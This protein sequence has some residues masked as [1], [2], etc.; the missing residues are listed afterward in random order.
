MKRI[1]QEDLDEILSRTE[2]YWRELARG[3]IFLTGC[4][5]FFGVWILECLLAAREKWGLRF[6]LS[7]LSRNPEAFLGVYPQF[8]GLSGV[9]FVRGDVV[10]FPS[11]DGAFSHVV[12]GAA[13]RAHETFHHEPPLAKFQTVAMGTRRVLDFC[14]EKKV[15]SVIYLGSGA[16][17]GRQPE[18]VLLMPEDG[19]VAPDTMNPHAALGHAKRVAEFFCAAYALE[20]D[21]KIKI[22]RCFSFVGPHLPLDIHYAIGNFIR[23]GIE[24]RAIKIKGDGQPVRS[25]LYM[26]D[27]V[28]WLLTILFNGAPLRIYHVGSE[29]G[30]S[31]GELAATVGQCFDPAVPVERAAEQQA[32]PPTASPDRYV[33]STQ[34]ARTELGLEQTVSLADAIRR[35]IK[36]HI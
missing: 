29:D 4:T 19:A 6:D 32:A 10:S 34:R 25:Y 11:P 21:L 36:F 28:I 22:A 7:L 31:I 8:A 15:E 26:T 12:H 24:G 5:G 14:V 17:C 18:N 35:T 2:H 3:R 9:Q 20:H 23:D 16:A 30:R 33:P 13:T 27:L 1:A